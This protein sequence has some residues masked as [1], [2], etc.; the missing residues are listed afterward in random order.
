MLEI[1]KNSEFH[2]FLLIV[3]VGSSVM[4]LFV[5][6]IVLLLF[7]SSFYFGPFGNFSS[8]VKIS[9]KMLELQRMIFL[10]HL[11]VFC[12]GCRWLTDISNVMVKFTIISQFKRDAFLRDLKYLAILQKTNLI[13]V[14]RE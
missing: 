14:S 11:L 2:D 10:L 1:Y 5:Q 6:M 4:L 3:L 7:C 13:W 9:L 8:L 12:T